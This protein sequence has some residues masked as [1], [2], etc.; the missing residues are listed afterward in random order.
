VS[1]GDL[2]NA[3][4]CEAA[5]DFQPYVARGLSSPALALHRLSGFKFSIKDEAALDAA[6]ITGTTSSAATLLQ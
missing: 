4:G 1:F 5:D 3:T 6:S 2:V